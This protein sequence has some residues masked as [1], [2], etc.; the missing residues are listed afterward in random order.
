[1]MKKLTPLQLFFLVAFGIPWLTALSMFL[2]HIEYGS[3]VSLVLVAGLYMT[4][5]ALAGW[6]ASRAEGIKPAVNGW[7]FR[8]LNWAV[9]ALVPVCMLLLVVLFFALEYLMG[10]MLHVKGFGTILSDRQEIMN[11]MLDVIGQKIK[12]KSKLNSLKS[13]PPVLLFLSSILN[14]V[15]A[16]ATVNMIFCFGEEYGWRGYL[17][18]KWRHFGPLKSMVVIGTIWGIWHWPIILMGHNYPSHRYLGCLVMIAF[19]ISVSLPLAWLR[20]RSHTIIGPSA[21]HGMINGV[22][23]LPMIFVTGSNELL[24][25]MPGLTGAAAGLILSGLILLFD[26]RFMRLYTSLFNR[27]VNLP[28]PVEVRLSGNRFVVKSDG[29]ETPDS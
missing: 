10:N 7:N 2:L 16:G 4:S 23:S 11:N 1:M 3:T 14:A 29:G 12:D 8:E 9:L 19:C 25:T 18:Q 22:A 5:P 24:G 27:K 6:L 15:I 21:L 17:L 13:I 20:L 28:P 26:R